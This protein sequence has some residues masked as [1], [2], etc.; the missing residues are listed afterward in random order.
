[1]TFFHTSN[2]Y[3]D[4]GPPDSDEA[5]SSATESPYHIQH[6]NQWNLDHQISGSSLGTPGPLHPHGLEALSAAALYTPPQANMTSQPVLD[7]TRDYEDSYTSLHTYNES[8]PSSDPPT[9]PVATNNNLHFLLNPTSNVNSPIDPSLMSPNIN[10]ALPT[11]NGKAPAHIKAQDQGADGEPESEHKVAFLLRHFSE[12]PG[13][14][15][16]NETFQRECHS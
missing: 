8:G 9:G 15:S 4:Q 6:E 2:P 10:E 7:H 13:Q 14:W 5:M 3:Q 11:H 12:S 1:M 16:V